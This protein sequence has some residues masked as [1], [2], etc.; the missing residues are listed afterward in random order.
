[1][2]WGSEDFVSLGQGNHGPD[3]QVQEFR[4]FQTRG[5]VMDGERLTRGTGQGSQPSGRTARNRSEHPVGTDPVAGSQSGV[6]VDWSGRSLASQ[7]EEKAKDEAGDEVG[8]EADAKSEDKVE[9]RPR[10]GG[11]CCR[12]KGGDAGVPKVEDAAEAKTEP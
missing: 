3:R 10:Q 11:R 1:M 6:P 8:D 5:G 7:I 9:R 12:G 2:V 4:A